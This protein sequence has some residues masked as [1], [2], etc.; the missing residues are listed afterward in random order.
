MVVEC[1]EIIYG[2]P[3]TRTKA[4]SVDGRIFEY[5]VWFGTWREKK[6]FSHYPATYRFAMARRTKGIK[7]IK[8]KIYIEV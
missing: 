6:S 4:L 1:V 8:A 3:K 7:S 2:L 5:N